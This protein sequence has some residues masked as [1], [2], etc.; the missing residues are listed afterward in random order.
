MKD[1]Y[2]EKLLTQAVYKKTASGMFIGNIPQCKG[3][4][5]YSDTLSQCQQELETV[6]KDWLNI[7]LAKGESIP[8]FEQYN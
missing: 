1:N 2:V 3:I 8:D 4:S 6:L 5:A 7:K